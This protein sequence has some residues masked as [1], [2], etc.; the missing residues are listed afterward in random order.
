MNK[1][2]FIIL[3][4][5]VFALAVCAVSCGSCEHVD[6]DDDG[7]CDIVDCGEAYSDGCDLHRDAND[8]RECDICNTGFFDACDVHCDANDDG[9]C[10][11]NGCSVEV[12]DGCDVHRDAD[13]NGLCDTDGCGISFT[14]GC[15]IHRDI[16]DDGMCDNGGEVYVDDEDINRYTV[17]VFDSNGIS[18]KNVHIAFYSQNTGVEVIGSATT[19]K[20]GE[21]VL[22][23]WLDGIRVKI[24]SLPYGYEELNPEATYTFSEERLEIILKNVNFDEYEGGGGTQLPVVPNN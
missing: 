11:T 14:D 8:D 23:T 22:D 5:V 16:N 4:L 20:N 2:K 13:D 18:V 7:K 6:K 24:I 3:L 9:E 1:R 12:D 10:D 21:A 17:A 19:D 15:D